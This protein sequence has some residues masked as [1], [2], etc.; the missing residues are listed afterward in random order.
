MRSPNNVNHAPTLTT[1]KLTSK[2]LCLAS[3]ALATFL[4]GCN[5][6][7]VRPPTPDQTIDPNAP[8]RRGPGATIVTPPPFGGGPQQRPDT[9]NEAGDRASLQAQTIYFGYDSSAIPRAE[10]TKL[11]A[12]QKYLAANPTVRLLLEGNCDWRGTAEYN[13]GLG[14]RRATAAKQYLEKLGVPAT[15]L[16]TLSKG[17]IGAPEKATEEQM[18]KDRRVEFVVLRADAAPAPLGL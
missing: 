16:E 4:A 1:M 2:T 15:R 10:Y 11:Q 14:D 12:V 17:S 3:L 13:L 8:A 7:P 5:H 18:S 9:S 6:T